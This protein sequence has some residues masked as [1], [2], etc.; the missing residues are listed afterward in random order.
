MQLVM[1]TNA[2]PTS[3]AYFQVKF[4]ERNHVIKIVF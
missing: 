2:A 1:T 4:H 3:S